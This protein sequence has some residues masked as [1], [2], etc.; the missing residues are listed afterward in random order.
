[1]NK[2]IL[3]YDVGPANNIQLTVEPRKD[4]GHSELSTYPDIYKYDDLIALSLEIH[5]VL[6]EAANI[7]DEGTKG[8]L[9]ELTKRGKKLRKALIPPEVIKMLETDRT[10]QHIMVRCNPLLN[11]VPYGCIFI[12]GDFLCFIRAIGKQLLSQKETQTVI[13]PVTDTYRGFNIVDPHQQLREEMEPNDYQNLEQEWDKF[14]EVWDAGLKNRISFDEWTFRSI[15]KDRVGHAINHN[16][17]VNF[18]CHHMYD[19]ENPAA[20]GYVL[21][22]DKS[23]K[24]IVVFTARDLVINAHG[25]SFRSVVSPVSH[26]VGKPIGHK[27][28]VFMVWWM[29]PS[30]KEFR[31]M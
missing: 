21:E 7:G 11:G 10:L 12:W 22:K 27:M 25:S 3:R 20:S 5:G 14:R 8:H 17:F 16:Q 2:L 9:E 26:E 30:A 1:M 4:N 6:Q 18:V 19:E 31:T 13:A 29:Q 15:S 28:S 24:P 23:G